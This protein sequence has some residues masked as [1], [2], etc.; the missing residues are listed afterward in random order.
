L[1][2]CKALSR[3]WVA[4]DYIAEYRSREAG[5][6]ETGQPS[7]DHDMYDV[8]SPR[9][10][11]QRAPS[12]ERTAIS[13]AGD[14]RRSVDPVSPLTA[15]VPQS[16]RGSP[17]WY[18]CSSP[19]QR[20]AGTVATCSKCNSIEEDGIV[21]TPARSARRHESARTF[22]RCNSMRSMRC[23]SGRASRRA[24]ATAGRNR[25]GPNPEC[26]STHRTAIL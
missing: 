11:Q 20:G 25:D 6:V 16:H 12:C 23:G 19:P 2:G 8:T 3:A 5:V 13:P 22:A 24:I 14:R 26:R 17:T 9:H 1:R 10:A 21:L 7:V 15:T 4:L 18:T